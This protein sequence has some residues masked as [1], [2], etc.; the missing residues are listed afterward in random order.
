MTKKSNKKGNL[1]HILPL[2]DSLP[3]PSQILYRDEAEAE[4]PVERAFIAMRPAV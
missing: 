3:P 2:P 1:F 4:F